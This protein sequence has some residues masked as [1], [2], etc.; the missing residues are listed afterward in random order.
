[1]T[2]SEPFARVIYADPAWDFTTW[3][4][5]AQ[6]S[7]KR[8]YSIMSRQQIMDLPV[9]EMALPGCV[10]LLWG[11]SPNLMDWQAVMSAWGFLYKTK[12]FCWVKRTRTDATW[13]MG[14]GYYTRANTEDCW[15]GVKIDRWTRTGKPIVTIPTRKSQ[16]VRQLVVERLRAHSQKPVQVYD[17]IERLFDGPYVELFA[18]ATR[19]GWHSWGLEVPDDPVVTQFLPLPERQPKRAVWPEQAISGGRP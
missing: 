16:G 9:G 8:Y 11:T 18:R 2:V 4:D 6:R 3:S 14:N 15:L 7:A 17:R 19:P 13:H 10:L 1:M 12:A 5:K